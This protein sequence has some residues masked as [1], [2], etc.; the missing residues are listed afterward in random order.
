MPLLSKALSATKP[1]PQQSLPA[2]SPPPTSLPLPSLPPP[3]LPTVLPP[4]PW[5]IA[6]TNPPLLSSDSGPY[7][8]EELGRGMRGQ[9][10]PL[11][12]KKITT[13]SYNILNAP[14]SFFKN[15]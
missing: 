13:S 10:P 12:A 1:P 7:S 4:Q 6:G 15:K 5:I 9:A 14:P 3:S 11:R 2:V 8:V